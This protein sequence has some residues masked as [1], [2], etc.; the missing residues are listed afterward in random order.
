ML[1][2]RNLPTDLQN[3][4]LN[5][6]DYKP[7][8]DEVLLD[9]LKNWC[10]FSHRYTNLPNS[11]CLCGRVV[12][13]ECI[14]ECTESNCYYYTLLQPIRHGPIYFTC[15][16]CYESFGDHDVN[17]ILEYEKHGN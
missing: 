7:M 11:P 4:V 3:L 10:F 5:Y 13:T 6:L 12:C 16:T 14:M 1:H 17:C 9:M 2:I 8:F 15:P